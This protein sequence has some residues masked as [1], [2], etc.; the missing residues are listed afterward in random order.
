MNRAFNFSAG[1]AA[2]PLPVLEAAAAGMTDWQG[3]GCGVLEMSHRG[4]AF[5]R[6]LEEA[7]AD[8]RALTGLPA[9]YKILFLQGGATL[10]FSQLVMNL[11]DGGSADYLVTGTWSKKA[12]SEAARL[13]PQLGGKVRL[14]GEAVGGVFSAFLLHD[15]A[16]VGKVM[17][18]RLIRPYLVSVCVERVAPVFE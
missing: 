9:Q 13:A 10:Q 4:A 14:A 16:D 3:A 11:L 6:I 15:A 1:P 12:Y 17:I 2:L 5:G 7:E 8:L 18:R